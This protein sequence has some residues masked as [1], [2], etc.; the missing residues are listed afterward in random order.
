MLTITAQLKVKP[1]SEEEARTALAGL[2]EPSRAEDGCLQYDMHI[3]TDDPK[4]FL[5]YERW[6]S[7]AHLDA[8]MQTEHF[9][10]AID[11]IEL[12]EEP[13]IEN[14]DLQ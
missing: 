11:A 9:K 5:F 4:T 1:G 12:T 8:H 14:W 7:Q 10:T 2:V 13:L 3:H 6:E